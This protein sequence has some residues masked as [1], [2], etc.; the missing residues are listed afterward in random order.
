M[1]VAAYSIAELELLIK[2]LITGHMC[3]AA[4]AFYIFALRILDVLV[5]A[6]P[7][8]CFQGYCP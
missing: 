1:L 8:V 4:S 7:L 2:R 3:M 6:V 5:V